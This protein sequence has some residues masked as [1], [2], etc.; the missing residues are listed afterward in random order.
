M[1][2]HFAVRAAIFLFLTLSGLF[3]AAAESLA[4]LSSISGV[5]QWRSHGSQAWVLLGRAPL[6]LG[7]GDMLRTGYGARARLDFLDGS[8]VELEGN[9]ALTLEEST[10]YRTAVELGPGILHV[11][12]KK[13][14]SR[15]FQVRTPVASCSA[16]GTEFRV[17]VFLGGRT[18]VDLYQGLLGVEDHK[19]QSVL[20][21]A[22]ERIEI[23][24]SGLSNPEAMP[25]AVEARRLSFNDMMRRELSLD[26]AQDA[27]Q[28]AAAREMR[29][30]QYQE[31]KVLT[32]LA[33]DRVRVEQYVIRPRPDQFKFV[34]LNGR[35]SRFDFFY[36]LGTFNQALPQDLSSA[37]AQ[38][39][40]RA[41]EAPDCWLTAFEAGRSNGKDSLVDAAQGGHP[42]DVNN[43]ADM[44]DDVSLLFDSAANRYV[45]VSGRPVYQT[46]FDRYG[47]YVNGGL[48]YGWTGNNLQSYAGAIAATTNDPVSGA[49]L[50]VALPTR[51]R[52]VT[53]PNG[54]E[55]HQVVC[56]YYEDGTFIQWD[57]R[58]VDGEGRAA[59]GADFAG[60]TGP[61]YQ[62]RLLHFN[63]EQTARASEFG[64]RKIDLVVAP[65]IL[66]QTG[67]IRPD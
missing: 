41:G 6:E 34:A 3:P 53:Y 60:L 54:Q 33:G 55:A 51:S 25:S 48:K 20:L 66:I 7:L 35:P 32:D 50:S 16:R 9:S 13:A 8:R 12:V 49:A 36:F 67:L 23:D 19:G 64:G 45:D 22:K 61:A 2:R 56:E 4:R 5:V 28:S 52:N 1:T 62:E 37:L 63:F 15:N 11:W 14:A 17:E 29:L 18:V 42:V 40:G 43:N 38:L 26:L 44:D 47:F 24:A 46:L 10:G 27:F 65:K 58:G 59:G 31:G 30:A 57:N 21:H 39:R